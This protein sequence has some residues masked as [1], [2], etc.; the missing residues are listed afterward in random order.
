MGKQTEMYVI[1]NNKNHF[2]CGPRKQFRIG[3][4]GFRMSG[5]RREREVKSGIL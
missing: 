2:L 4:M 3:F 5:R 1:T